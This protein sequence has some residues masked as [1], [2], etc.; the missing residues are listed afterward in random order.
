MATYSF[1]ADDYDHAPSLLALLGSVW[2]LVYDERD[3]LEV[4][5]AARGQL[6]RQLQQD[7]TEYRQLISRHDAPVTHTEHWQ[8]LLLTSA[9]LQQDPR[10]FTRV[11]DDTIGSFQVGG[12]AAATGY[13]F[14]APPHVTAVRLI[15]NRMTAPSYVATPAVD[16]DLQDGLIIFRDNPLDNPLIPRRRN[17]EDGSDSVLLWMSDV[18]IDKEYLF[19]YFGYV[20]GIH[21]QSSPNYKLVLNAVFNAITGAVSRTDIEQLLAAIMG[22]PLAAG[23][24]TVELV[25]V[26]EH[27]VI[28]TDKNVYRFPADT[29]VLVEPAEELY[30]GQPLTDRLRVYELNRGAVPPMTQMTL[31]RGMLRPGLGPLTFENREVPWEVTTAGGYTRMACDLGGF[32]A[33]VTAFWDHVHQAG[34]AAEE[35]LASLLDMRGNKFGEPAAGNLPATVNPLDFMITNLLHANL[36]VV[37]AKPVGATGAGLQWT[38]LLRRIMPPHVTTV[39]VVELQLLSDSV[40]IDPDD[41]VVEMMSGMEPLL[42]SFDTDNGEDAALAPRLVSDSC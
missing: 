20:L 6:E 5:M 18:S 34:I 35:T 17:W 9:D 33:D 41:D 13:A 11:G 23:D 12:A 7:V 10:T 31:E 39:M 36:F 28:V 4:L 25:T 19:R 27:T 37:L 14:S 1:P 16:F 29:T 42:D 2:T 15:T 24:E 26:G 8:P 22:V 3:Q 21:M 30:A 40:T 38:Q 32:P